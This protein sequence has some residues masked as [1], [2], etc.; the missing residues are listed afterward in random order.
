MIFMFLQDQV[1]LYQVLKSL[2]VPDLQE[3]ALCL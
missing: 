2:L 3:I 1:V